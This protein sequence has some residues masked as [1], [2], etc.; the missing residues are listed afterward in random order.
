MTKRD[1]YEVLSASKSAS[2]EE[3]KKSYR[4]VALKHHPDRNPGDSESEEKFKEAA[5]A[6]EVL[7]N[8]DKRAKY[9]RF[10]HQGVK[11]GM[12]GFGEGMTMDDIFSH[13]G[14]VFGDGGSPF[15]SFFG[16]SSGGGR[17]G[18]GTRGSTL[19]IK[20]KLTLLEIAKGIKKSVKV[21]KMVSC[22]VCNGSGAKDSNSVDT[23]R[24]CGGA[25]AVRKVTNT[26]LG[27]MQT[28][29]TCPTCR[30]EGQ[31]ITERCTECKGEGRVYKE[32]MIDIE[33]PAGVVEDV[34][35]SMNGKGNAGERGGSP[36]DLIIQIEE[37]KD[38][39]LKRVSNDVIY[40]LHLN[41][42][43]AA[44]GTSIEVPTIEGKAKIKIPPG[45]QAGKVFRLKGK[46]IPSLERSYQVGDQL[47]DV[48]VWTP[49]T[50]TKE[51]RQILE[52]LKK[53]PNF[54][55]DPDSDHKGL[56]DRFKDFFHA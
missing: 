34:Q 25:G 47:I 40:G 23:C 51:E 42:A 35:L 39:N 49:K 36:G 28:T 16:G 55:P 2:V 38:E 9:D 26:I 12:G 3:I 43:D 31:T 44:L 20:V 29:G 41:F 5:E 18:S 52:K 11:G 8:I 10:G 13:F 24:T 56:F 7:G 50:L 1:Y 4:K 19:R 33:I 54:E 6:Y 27:Q 48:N 46:G 21:N 30:G 15:D 14:D 22:D 37:V 17:R 45:T 32:D 53:S